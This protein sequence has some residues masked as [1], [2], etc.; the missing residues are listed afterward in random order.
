ML[1]LV[2]KIKNVLARVFINLRSVISA[3]AEQKRADCTF[4]RA[5][6]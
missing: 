3:P 5:A 1:T 6:N 2:I 4:I